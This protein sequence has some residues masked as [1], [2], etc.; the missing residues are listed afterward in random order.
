MRAKDVEALGEDVI[1]DEASVDGEGPHQDNDVAALEDGGEYLQRGERREGGGREQG[2]R[3]GREGGGNRERGGR[4]GNMSGWFATTM[5]ICQ[6]RPRPAST[7][8][9]GPAMASSSPLH[10]P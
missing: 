7:C 10:L 9:G 5:S 4:G 1:V 3:G 2:E 8:T 6:A